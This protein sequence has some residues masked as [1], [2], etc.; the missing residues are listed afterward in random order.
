[1]THKK[2]APADQDRSGAIRSLFKT[3]IDIAAPY[4]VIIALLAFCFD[5]LVRWWL[6]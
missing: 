4:L 2:E 1:M 6:Q 3:A 5:H